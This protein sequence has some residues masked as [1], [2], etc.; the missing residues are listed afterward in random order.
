MLVQMHTLLHSDQQAGVRASRWWWIF[1][2]SQP[3]PQ[4]LDRQPVGI[5]CGRCHVSVGLPKPDHLPLA[6][7]LQAGHTEMRLYPVGQDDQAC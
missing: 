1:G 6:N 7:L 3:L 4:H 5:G 2:P